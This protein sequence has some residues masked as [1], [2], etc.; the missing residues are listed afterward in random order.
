MQFYIFTHI[1]ILIL[2]LYYEGINS[3]NELKR[4]NKKLPSYFFTV[5]SFII[6]FI[7]SAFRGDFTTDYKSYTRLFYLYNQYDFFDVLKV[8]DIESGYKL[9]SRSVGVFTDNEMY[10]FMVVSFIILICFYSQFKKHSTY[11]WLSVLMFVIIGSYYSSFNIIRQILAVAIIFAGSKFLYERRFFKYLLVVILASLF[12]STALIM[13]AF[14]FILNFR[15]N[16]RSIFLIF[17]GSFFVMLFLNNIVSFFQRNFYTSYVEGAYGMEG[18]SFK[19]AIIPM[20]LLIFSLFN[21]KKIDLSNTIQRIWLNAVIFNAFFS[22]LGTKVFMI[23][24]VSH[25]FSS[26]TLLLIPLLFSKIKTKELRVVLIIILVF[27]LIIYHYIVYKN[28]DFDPYYFIWD[29]I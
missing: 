24:R 5:P 7:I 27:F 22:I 4:R 16:F 26:Y 8:T 17:C 3:M 19:I 25:F 1:T 6:L 11:M 15:F 14:Y 18:A 28:T 12:H 29:T 2:G 9:L 10:L 21:Y 23:N 13:I 20:A